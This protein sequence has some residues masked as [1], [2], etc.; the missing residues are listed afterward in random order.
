MWQ[1]AFFGK[2]YI[3]S[4]LQTLLRPSGQTLSDLQTLCIVAINTELV[5]ALT[6]EGLMPFSDNYSY[7]IPYSRMTKQQLR[8]LVAHFEQD[9]HNNRQLFFA[10]DN[11]FYYVKMSSQGEHIDEVNLLYGAVTLMRSALITSH[12]NVQGHSYTCQLDDC[13]KTWYIDCAL[14]KII[15]SCRLQSRTLR[16]VATLLQDDEACAQPCTP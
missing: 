4:T 6:M 11:N 12:V 10:Q 8:T 2:E 7:V 14:F 15:N 1:Q 16:S 3:V 13:D 5:P 9:A